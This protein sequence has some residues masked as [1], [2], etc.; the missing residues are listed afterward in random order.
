[1]SQAMRIARAARRRRRVR[2][3]LRTFGRGMLFASAL[4]VAL[5]L[6]DR[7]LTLDLPLAALISPPAALVLVMLLVRALRAEPLAPAAQELDDALGLHDSI[8]TGVE[9]ESSRAEGPFE[10]LALADAERVAAETKPSRGV[11]IV[12]ARPHRWWPILAAAFVGLAIWLPPRGAVTQAR[13][14]AEQRA[15]QNAARERIAEVREQTELEIEAA[16]ELVDEATRR[17]L[18]ALRR[19]EEELEQ[20]FEDPE[21][22]GAK[23]AQTLTE[24]AERMEE[25]AAQRRKT[26]EELSRRV[27]DTGRDDPLSDAL[28]QGDFASAAEELSEMRRGLENASPEERRAIAERLR[29]AA[30]AID[31]SPAEAP[32][33]PEERLVEEGVDPERAK[34]LASETD[35]DRLRE[36]LEREGADPLEAQRLADELAEQARDREAQQRA[37]ETA[38][39][40]RESLERAAE[41]AEQPDPQDGQEPQTE[42]QPT[43]P[44]SSGPQPA[45][46][47]STPEQTPGPSP[48]SNQEQEGGQDQESPGQGDQPDQQ[49]GG[50][51]GES[52]GDQPGASQPGAGPSQRQG[53]E[54][55]GQQE[56][57]EQPG[58]Q[59][60]SPGSQQGEGDGLDRAQRIAQELD[61]QGRDA[62]SRSRQAERFREGADRLAKRPPSGSTGSDAGGGADRAPQARME[63]GDS[64]DAL[65]T[66]GLDIRRGA[67]SE[68]TI[69][70]VDAEG[71]AKPGRTPSRADAERTLEQAAP[72]AE[73]AL[74][75]QGVPTRFR[76]LVKRY[77]RQRGEGEPAPAPLAPPD[78]GAGE[79]GS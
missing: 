10:Q 21:E 60:G 67:E 41:Q 34:E 76:E 58:S 57:G 55:P 51:Q 69:A 52:S 8:S 30:E 18:E 71:P 65:Q 53:G 14:A 78:N 24:A 15:E 11:R 19:I 26:I 27:S 64:S 74:E 56:G 46:P 17:D 77:F 62:A 54:R 33:S 38:G 40:L 39:E 66:E 59:P 49:P 79:G 50:Q 9:L 29:R 75:N 1:M 5:V 61:E 73:R 32:P 63:P 25:E 7:W 6:A 72:G 4:G 16:P 68:R 47:G 23:A 37:E 31:D 43:D 22:A 42:D 20:G 28:S 36:S 3:L 48:P 2:R 44:G 12:D 45:Q 13:A 35:R 70:E